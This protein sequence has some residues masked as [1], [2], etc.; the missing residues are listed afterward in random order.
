VLPNIFIPVLPLCGAAAER[1]KDGACTAAAPPAP[2]A[3]G[4]GGGPRCYATGGMH[5]LEEAGVG[6]VLV[7]KGMETM[8]ALQV[9]PLLAFGRF[10]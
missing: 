5:V 7:R 8:V 9:F 3:R 10:G 1:A 2:L 6:A 4:V